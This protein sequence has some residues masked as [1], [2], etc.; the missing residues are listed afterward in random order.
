METPRPGI[1][2]ACVLGSGAF[3][4]ALAQLM[5]RQGVLT[6]AWT[7]SQDVTDL[8]TRCVN[9]ELMSMPP[10]T[11]V[12]LWTL[13]PPH[14]KRCSCL[15][16]ETFNMG[17]AYTCATVLSGTSEPTTTTL[18]PEGSR[19]MPL[20]CQFRCRIYQRHSPVYRSCVVWVYT[21]AVHARSSVNLATQPERH[22]LL[23]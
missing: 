9:T 6:T 21:T 8:I 14:S 20:R 13:R 7:R 23:R 22:F 19:E 11:F 17:R 18:E 15:E 12:P 1:K 10:P 5:A 4:T 2:K 3:G 16:M